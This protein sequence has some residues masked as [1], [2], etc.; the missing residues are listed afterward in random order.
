[1]QNASYRQSSHYISVNGVQIHVLNSEKADE[2]ATENVLVLLHGFT[3]NAATWNSLLDQ[4]LLPGL[5]I[6]AFDLLGHGLS[7][8]PSS[9]QRYAIEYCCEDIV[10][11]LQ[12]LGIQPGNAILLG[13]SLGGRI[14][15]YS[16]FSGFFRALIL[17]SS[18]PGLSNSEERTQRY[19]SD[20]KLA[21]RI[22]REGILAF[23]EYWEQIPLF[24]S[25][26]RLPAEKR[27]ALHQQRLTNTAQGLAASLRGVG[28][29][30]QPS[31]YERLPELRLP[32]QL[33][34]GAEDLKFCAIADQMYKSLPQAA[35]AIVPEAG[36]TVHL[37]QPTTYAEIVRGFCQKCYH[38]Q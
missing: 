38:K 25:Q 33:I 2:Q 19:L 7:D 9:A 1:M 37:E 17:E 5:R 29:G 32:V 22:E 10:A 30:A 13:Y 31:L 4:L 36:H 24:A 26:R 28:T 8:A 27:L 6:I 14:A 12:K 15:L 20:L 16:A 11:V 21:E 18:S 35:L 34:V 23:V 3:G